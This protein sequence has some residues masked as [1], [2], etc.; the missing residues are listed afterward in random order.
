MD[1]RAVEPESVARC[2]TQGSVFGFDI[3]SSLAFNLLRLPM[4]SEP[5]EIIAAPVTGTQP[6]D[7]LVF[8]VEQEGLVARIYHDGAAYR[9]WVREVGWFEIDP[10]IPRVVVPVAAAT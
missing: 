1:V 3:H 2:Q 8:E 7:E 10:A 9:L 5:L 4:G 6:N